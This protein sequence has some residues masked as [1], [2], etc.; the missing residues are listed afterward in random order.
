MSAATPVPGGIPPQGNTSQDGEDSVAKLI[1]IAHP[2]TF[3]ERLVSWASRPPG[4]LYLPA[5]VF[6][7]LIL[8]YEDSMP[9]GHLPSFLIGMGAGALLAAMGALRLGIALSLARPMI[10]RY[11]LRW[12]TAPVIALATIVLSVSDVP[13][14]ARL[15]ASTQDLLHLRATLDRS[16]T[17]PLNGEWAGLYP[18]QAATVTDGVTRFTVEGA[19][20]LDGSGLAYSSE[21][22]ETDQ[23]LPGHGG[24][25][26]EHISGPWYSWSD[27]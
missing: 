19:G 16:T 25:V 12:L 7:G 20:L 1:E 2:P 11:W 4:R 5:C 13:L 22:L 14:K 23:F 9:G 24:V 26:Y 10:R 8:L 27:Y 17:I 15:D 6:T 21:P 3:G 18:L